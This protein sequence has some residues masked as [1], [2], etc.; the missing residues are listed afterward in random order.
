MAGTFSS[1]SSLLA[2]TKRRS[3]FQRLMNDRHCATSVR[4]LG[5]L[6]EKNRRRRRLESMAQFSPST[7]KGC[8]ISLGGWPL[9]FCSLALALALLAAVPQDTRAVIL[10]LSGTA[11]P[12]AKWRLMPELWT[13]PPPSIV[14]VHPEHT[15]RPPIGMRNCSPLNC[16]YFSSTLF[17]PSPEPSPAGG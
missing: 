8:A 1:G 10:N 4:G 13:L 2:T 16:C 15:S 12:A 6:A 17:R 3:I 11:L 9:E 14:L 7:P 5:K